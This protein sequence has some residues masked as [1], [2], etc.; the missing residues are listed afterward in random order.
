MLCQQLR[1][2]VRRL[3]QLTPRACSPEPPTQG[4]VHFAA[5]AIL[6]AAGREHFG[7]LQHTLR[8]WAREGQCLTSPSH[9]AHTQ[10][11]ESHQLHRCAQLVCQ[12]RTRSGWL[13]SASARLP[14]SQRRQWP[15][16]GGLL[17]STATRPRVPCHPREGTCSRTER[18]CGGPGAS[19]G[20]GGSFSVAALETGPNGRVQKGR[21]VT[22]RFR[23]LLG[24]PEL[25]PERPRP[26]SSGLAESLAPS[27]SPLRK[28][29]LLLLG[30]AAGRR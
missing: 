12:L 25:G 29:L 3:R 5:V 24:Q 15:E 6:N 23:G 30:P 9:A 8:V 11:Q 18:A 28:R 13:C 21:A 17:I 16:D 2:H 27:P 20:G 10:V 4:P 14:G 1:V 22:S 26:R 7:Y 19:H